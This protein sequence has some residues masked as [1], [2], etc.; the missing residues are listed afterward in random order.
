MADLCTQVRCQRNDSRRSECTA[1]DCSHLEH[2]AF[3]ILQQIESRQDCSLH[4]IGEHRED[5]LD[6][7]LVSQ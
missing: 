2:A 4:G 1:K 3:G 6:R 7:R 5:L